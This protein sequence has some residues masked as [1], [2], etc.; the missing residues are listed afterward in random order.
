MAV[1]YLIYDT[2]T[3]LQLVDFLLERVSFLGRFGKIALALL[4][5]FLQLAQLLLQR[6]L[7]LCISLLRRL[8]RHLL[9]FCFCHDTLH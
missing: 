5:V 8:L 6:A 9:T 3:R 2:A 4:L 1:P 7:F